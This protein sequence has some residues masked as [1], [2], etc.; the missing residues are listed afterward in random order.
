MILLYIVIIYFIHLL[1]AKIRP[2][3]KEYYK[4]YK[5]NAPGNK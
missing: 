3:K 5:L 1:L 2:V 4:T